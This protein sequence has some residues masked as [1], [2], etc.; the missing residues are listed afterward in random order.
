MKKNIRSVDGNDD[1]PEDGW[2]KG[3]D[4]FRFKAGGGPSKKRI[5]STRSKN[6]RVPKPSQE[7]TNKI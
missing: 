2:K 7:Y 5:G 6:I 3:E 1:G 4:L